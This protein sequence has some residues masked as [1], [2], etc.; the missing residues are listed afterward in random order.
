MTTSAYWRDELAEALART[1]TRWSVDELLKAV[2]SG[3]A[4][5][6]S[7]AGWLSD[8]MRMGRVHLVAGDDP[9]ARPLRYTMVPGAGLGGR[10]HQR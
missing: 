8:E 10:R 3:D 5:L 9:T 7:V 2:S 4:G 1:D 6:A